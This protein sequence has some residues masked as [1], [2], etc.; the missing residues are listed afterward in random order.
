MKTSMKV[1]MAAGA[2]AIVGGVIFAGTSLADRGGFG[3]HGGMHIGAMGAVAHQMLADVDANADGALSQEEIDAAINL[4]FSEFDLNADQALSLEEFKAL[5]ASITEPAAVRAFQ[6][7]D[8]NGDASVAKAE[9]DE[10]FGTVVSR[11]DHNED[12]LLSPDDRRGHRGWRHGA[13]DDDDEERE[14]NP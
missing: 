7:L 4:R 9:L 10:R 3:G 14:L 8:P 2:V 5:W 12:G 11:F 1:A 6:F 13:W